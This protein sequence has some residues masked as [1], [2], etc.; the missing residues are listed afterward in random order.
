MT[1]LIPLPQAEIDRLVAN[2]LTEDWGARG[3]ITS[4]AVIGGTASATAIMRARDAG[5]LAG[6][7]FALATFAAA[8][9]DFTLTAHKHDGEAIAP[10]DNI[11]TIE[12]PAAA[13]LSAERVAL[14][15]TGHL[16]GIASQTAELVALVAHT[17]AAICDTRKTL[18]GLRAAQKYAVRAGGGRNHRFGLYD[19]ILI[20]DNH[21]AVAGGIAPALQAARHGAGHMISI[22]I[23]VDTLDQLDAALAAGADIV[24]LDNMPPDMLGEA[25][26]RAKGKAVTEASGR[27]S[28]ETVVA[29]AEAGVD[30]ISVGALTHSAAVLD[31]GLDIDLD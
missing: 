17:E 1:D 18:P 26:A 30:L 13:L 23:E 25:V 5:V 19:A 12:G 3:D 29:I 22:E 21:I 7:P 9:P 24:L 11:L 4:Q 16:S 28:A 14:N 10:G 20:K 2:A 8:S 31:L 27:V 15:F 6:L